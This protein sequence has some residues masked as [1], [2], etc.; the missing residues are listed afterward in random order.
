MLSKIIKFKVYYDRGA[1]PFNYAKGLIIIA[2][3][4]K[5]LVNPRIAEWVESHLFLFIPVIVLG[6][7]FARVLWGYFD[8]KFKI[9]EY[10]I[11]EYNKT[12]PNL[13]MIQSHLKYIKK[14]LD[15]N[16]ADSEPP[17]ED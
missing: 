15:D 10:E 8:K 3:A 12:D 11:A 16:S 5:L 2:L 6:Y 13:R 4:Y 1:M 7:I 17:R 9:R 14:K